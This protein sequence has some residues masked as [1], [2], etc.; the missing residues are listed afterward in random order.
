MTTFIIVPMLLYLILQTSWPIASF[1]Q[2]NDVMFMQEKL[3][4]INFFTL[5]FPKWTHPSLN[6]E[7]SITS[8]LDIA[9]TKIKNKMP[10]SIVT[11]W[12]RQCRS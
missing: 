10:N 11:K 9:Y 1:R 7:E 2:T 4:A 5:D 8:K 6:L 3:F 12:K